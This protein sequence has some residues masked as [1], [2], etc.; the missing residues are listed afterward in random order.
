MSRGGSSSVFRSEFEPPTLS[1][2]AGSTMKTLLRP[3]YGRSVAAAT[4]SRTCSTLIIFLSAPTSV[5]CTSG[6]V[7]RSMRWHDVQSSP[8]VPLRQLSVLA[9][10]TATSRNPCGDGPWQRMAWCNSPRRAVSSS[11]SAVAL[12]ATPP[13]L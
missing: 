3:S 13:A 5:Q 1:A 10:P 2:S 9:M 12:M 4:M 11:S 7:R 6:C 8:S